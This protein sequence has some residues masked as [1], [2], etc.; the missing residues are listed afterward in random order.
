MMPEMDGY[1]VIYFLG[2]DNKTASIPFIFLT[3]KSEKQDFRKGMELGADDYLTK[4]FDDVTLVKAIDQRIN[5]VNRSK[6]TDTSGKNGA[7]QNFLDVFSQHKKTKKL[8]SKSFIYLEHSSPVYLFKVLKGQVKIFS[9]N[10]EGKELTVKLISENEYFG[11]HALLNNQNYP[12]SA[13]SLTEVK[14]E[15]IP[16]DS[17]LNY[18][19]TNTEL[20]N[21]FI[22]LLSRDTIEFQKELL[23]K[24]YDSVKKR[25]ANGLVKYANKQPTNSLSVPREELAHLA[26]TSTESVIRTLSEFKKD[27]LIEVDGKE[28]IIKKKNELI[29][30]QY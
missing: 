3:A 23:S 5:K 9:T 6:N 30:Y 25:V 14:L 27:G 24:T 29:N 12:D 16:G 26:G 28:I 18:I 7:G 21:Y 1:D 4:P 8:D 11:Y 15:L 13:V 17:F 10:D 22:K 2:L 20:S 19:S